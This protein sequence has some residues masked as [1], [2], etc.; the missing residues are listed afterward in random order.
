[1]VL[2]QKH[3]ERNAAEQ[4]QLDLELILLSLDIW[5]NFSSDCG[6]FLLLEHRE[7][8]VRVGGCVFLPRLVSRNAIKDCYPT[9]EYDRKHP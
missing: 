9:S 7:N 3:T 2:T 8:Q 5:P 1:M 4:I 6:V